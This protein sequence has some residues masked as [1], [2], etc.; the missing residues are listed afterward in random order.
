MLLKSQ[1]A[2]SVKLELKNAIELKAG[3]FLYLLQ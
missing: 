2:F 3:I 1:G